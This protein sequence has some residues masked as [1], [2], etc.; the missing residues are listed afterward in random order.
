[1]GG[2]KLLLDHFYTKAR[3]LFELKTLCVVGI[4]WR[5]TKSYITNTRARSHAST[6][7]NFVQLSWS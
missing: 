2:K 1:M 4:A 6:P 5:G 3:A 7:E